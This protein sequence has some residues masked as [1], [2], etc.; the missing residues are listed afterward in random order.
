M[1]FTIDLAPL[2][3]PISDRDPAGDWL[4]YEGTY[5]AI[6]EARRE[7]DDSLPQGIWQS[8]AKRADWAKVS[9][10]AQKALRERSKDLQLSAWLTE[11]WLQLYGLPGLVG[12]FSLCAQL[13]ERFWTTIYPLLEESDPTYRLAPLEF[14]DRRIAE[15]LKQVALTGGENDAK[16]YGFADWER[17]LRNDRLGTQAEPGELLPATFLSAASATAPAFYARLHAQLGQAEEATLGLEQALSTQL[18]FHPRAFRLVRSL[19]RDIQTLIGQYTPAAAAETASPDPTSPTAISAAAETVASAE[20]SPMSSEP[21]LGNS[22]GP[23]RSRSDAYQ[24][25]VDA[26]EYLMRT[27]PHSPVPYLVKRAVSWGNM[28]LAQLLA[29]LVSSDTERQPIFALLGMRSPH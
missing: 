20:G 10:L 18:P 22:S 29:E 3:T 8:K 5:D 14:L 9:T 23:I 15:L 1:P 4:R 12:G 25:L 21:A 2:L 13:L 26:A 6:A 24:R 11:A 17:A 28:S 7:D 19:L 27:E 16:A